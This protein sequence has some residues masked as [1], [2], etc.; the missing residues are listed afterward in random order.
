MT[1]PLLIAAALLAFAQGPIRAAD[2]PPNIILVLADDL[3]IGHLG[4]YGQT[5]FRTPAIDRLAAEGTKFTNYYCGAA[6]CAPSRS[7]LMTGLHTGHTPVRNNGLDRYLYDKDVTLAEVL[8]RAGYATGGF[9]K[10]GLGRETTPG[11]AVR[12]GFDVWFGQYSQTHAHFHYPAYLFRNLERIPVPENEGHRRARYAPDIIHEQ[13]LDFVR[14]N[15]HRP[16]F[17]YLAYTLPHVELTV[18]E[19]SRRPYEGRWPKIGRKDPRPGYIGSDDAYAD[20]AGMVGH[21]DR[22]VGEVLAL[23]QEL[24]LDRR[25]IVLFSSD[26]GPLGGAWSDISLDFFEGNGP[27]RGA[28][29]DFYEGGIRAPLLVRWP[30]VVRPGSVSDHVTSAA[31]I[32]PTLAEVAGAAH[33]LPAPIDGISFAPTLRGERDRQQ[34]HEFLYWEEAGE[35]QDIRQQ[36]VRLGDWKAVRRR[37]GAAWELYDLAQDPGEQHDVA[38]DHAAALAR[39]EAIAAAA[40]SPERIYGPTPREGAADYV[41]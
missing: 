38:A 24:D 19:A 21:L 20:F 7:V 41:K 31:D 5:K 12:Q 36:A 3:G 16:F 2:P 1:R 35:H 18:P 10:W 26:N 8:H 27:Y 14:A 15:R 23:L 39:I 17:A 34:R 4:C 30:G 29:E 33:L 28:K 22:Q 40:H 32:L 37:P 6:V 9:G 11:V 25:T 13:A